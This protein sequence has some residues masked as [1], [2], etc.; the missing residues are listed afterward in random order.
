[1]DGSIEAGDRRTLTPAVLASAV[2]VVACAVGA[3]A[4]VAARG[5]L[6]MP[7]AATASDAATASPAPSPAPSSPVVS[8]PA[9]TPSPVS[10]ATTAPTLPPTTPPATPAATPRPSPAG[11]PDP[12]TALPPCPGQPGCYEYRI[13]RGDTLSGVAS[14]YR[15]PVLVVLALNPELDDPSTIVVG[16]VLYLGREPYLRLEPCPDATSCYRYVVQPGDTLS[17]IAGRFRLTV[18]AILAANPSIDDESTIFSG[19]VIR[20]QYPEG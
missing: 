12:L 4:F 19:Q 5:G 13:Q 9:P 7:I 11:S 2:F 20:L 1:M 6:E 15:I 10:A 8:T 16:E 14:R 18:E 17:T 3:I